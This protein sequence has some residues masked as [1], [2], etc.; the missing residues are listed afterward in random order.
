MSLI[1]GATQLFTSSQHST[2]SRF[3]IKIFPVVWYLDILAQEERAH[4]W[5]RG[6]CVWAEELAGGHRLFFTLLALPELQE[7]FEHMETVVN[8][9]QAEQGSCCGIWNQRGWLEERKKVHLACSTMYKQLSFEYPYRNE[10]TLSMERFSVQSKY[11][12]WVL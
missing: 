11:L 4:V 2:F 10:K 12:L 6:G 3:K 8:S 5:G 9:T 1:R 7:W